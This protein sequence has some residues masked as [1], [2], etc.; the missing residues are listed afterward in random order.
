LATNGKTGNGKAGNA[1][2]SYRPDIDGIRSLAILSVVLFHA[3]VPRL[4]GGF[5]G[6][7]VF[8][9]LSGYLIGGHIFS[10]LQ[11]GRFSYLR[12]YQRR[13]K[14]ILPA[15]YTVL[16]FTLAATVF[17]LTPLNGYHMA[18][19]AFWATLSVSNIEFWKTTSYFSPGSEFNPV[20]MTWSLGVEEQFYVVI[21]LLMVLLA[22]IRRSWVL[23]SILAVCAASFWFAVAMLPS[24]PS[25]VFYLL[26]AR[27]WELGIGV[28]LAVVELSR[29]RYT[30]SGPVA[31]A[32]GVVG[33]AAVVLPFFLLNKLTPFPG[34]AAVPSV[35]GTGLLLAVPQSW[36]NRRV[37]SLSPLVYV[38]RVSYSWYLW[39]WPVLAFLRTLYGSP[40]VPLGVG[41]A[42]VALAFGAAVVSY[43]VIE[44]PFRQSKRAPKPLLLR[45]A[46][47]TVVYLVLFAIFVKGHGFPARYPV[48]SQ[49]ERV[50]E[51]RGTDPCLVG[52]GAQAPNTVAEC[53]DHAGT[54]PLVALWGDSHSGA[55]APGVRATAERSGY[56]FVQMSKLACLPLIGAVRYTPELPRETPECVVFNQKALELLKA[57]SRIHVVVLC[58]FWANPF[59]LDAES[60]EETWLT[61]DV[62]HE[63]ERPTREAARRIFVD[64]MTGTIRTLQA[65]G[66]QVVVLGD[67]PSFTFDPTWKVSTGAIPAERVLLKWLRVPNIGDPGYAAPGHVESDIY[68]NAAVHEALTGVD[69][70]HL[71]EIKQKLCPEAGA[72]LYRDGDRLLYA[73]SH[74]LTADGALFALR[75]FRVADAR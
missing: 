19:S 41:L 23:P 4:A 1:D 40:T 73:D 25:M 3:G 58:G 15:F 59:R 60:G 74:H 52:D 71:V 66:K 38:G 9:V 51:L 5:T 63:R 68:G 42:A 53:Y 61:S 45:Y 56:G 28:A 29:G 10:E 20:L 39:H 13:A 65:M 31:E 72:C 64:A 55:M 26:P 34:V 32:M 36:V 18:R 12:F 11:A 17:L 14:R 44:Q 2:R 8:F 21:P 47:V 48:L 57:D 43:Y 16:A 70:V 49:M 30:K 6:V 24:Y 67:T 50:T 22:R 35:L 69:G 27:A 37:L 46:A 7:D 75:D 33:L 62:A 54:K